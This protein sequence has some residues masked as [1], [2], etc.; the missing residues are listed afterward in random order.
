MP[1]VSWEQNS[2]FK[3][4]L[5]IA[6][7]LRILN[8]S[9]NIQNLLLNTFLTISECYLYNK[10]MK[11]YG[12]FQIK[13]S[14]EPTHGSVCSGVMFHECAKSGMKHKMPFRILAHN[15][16]YTLC[17]RVPGSRETTTEIL[18]ARQSVAHAY[19]H[20]HKEIYTRG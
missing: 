2:F 10:W 5:E 15:V 14:I 11:S 17:L 9:L 18:N 6:F 19:I 8:F 4:P 20:T 1:L 16:I 3:F 12:K 7:C 13:G